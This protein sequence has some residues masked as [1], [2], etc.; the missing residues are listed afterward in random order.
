M[1][2]ISLI[3]WCSDAPDV[4]EGL[5]L[6]W[7]QVANLC[8]QSLP[9]MWETVMVRYNEDGYPIQDTEYKLEKVR[10]KIAAGADVVD[11]INKTCDTIESYTA[12]LREYNLK[13]VIP[14]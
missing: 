12:A 11:A 13:M 14:D 1:R 4:R 2:S 6:V 8:G 7:I 9:K 5:P 3:R 10:E